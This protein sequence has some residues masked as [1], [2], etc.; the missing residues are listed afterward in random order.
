MQEYSTSATTQQDKMTMDAFNKLFIH[1]PE[2][3]VIL[4]RRCKH[5]VNPAQIKGHITA[6]HC[7]VTKQQRQQIVDFVAGLSH[8]AHTPDEVRYPDVSSAAVAGLPIYD[9][10]LRC[11]AQ[12]NGRACSRTYREISG[13]QRHCHTEHG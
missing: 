12:V 3:C 11:T 13:I 10:G 1:Q 5:A 7:G 2:Y 4:C 6:N 9:N 8:V